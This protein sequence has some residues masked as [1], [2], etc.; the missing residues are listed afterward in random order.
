MRERSEVEDFLNGV[1]KTI[2]G[3]TTGFE[4]EPR[5]PLAFIMDAQNRKTALFL[6]GLEKFELDRWMPCKMASYDLAVVE[7]AKDALGRLDPTLR[8][9]L[10]ITRFER[11]HEIN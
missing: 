7:S 11:N 5:H 2:K 3:K 1:Y 6:Y 4:L 10:R 9:N 8:G